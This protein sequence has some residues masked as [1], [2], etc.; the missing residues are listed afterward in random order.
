MGSRVRVSATPCGFRGGRNE[1]WISFFRSFS[2]FPPPH[3]SFLHFSTVISF[4][5]FHYFRPYDGTSGMIGRHP[6]YSQTS[7]KGIHRVS[8]L[9]LVL[10]R[11]EVED[12]YFLVINWLLK[13]S[14]ILLFD[15]AS[16]NL[17]LAEIKRC[18]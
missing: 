2:R 7:N 1:I 17:L 5:S 3:I 9:D 11:P 15:L 10:C 12:I 4:I 16:H 14:V 13:S 6:W 18:P 8:S